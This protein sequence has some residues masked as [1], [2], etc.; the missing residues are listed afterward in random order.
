MGKTERNNIEMY[1]EWYLNELKDAGYIHRYT[2]EAE[3]FEL[4]PQYK[5][6]RNKRHK[7]KEPTVEE[8]NLLQKLVYTYDYRIYWENKSMYLFFQE[9]DFS[10]RTKLQLQKYNHTL[11]WAQYDAESKMWVSDVDVKPVPNAARF[12]KGLNSYITFPILQKALL[13]LYGRY[14]NK[15][16][17]IPSRSS[18]NTLALFP[19]SFTPIRY[20]HTDKATMARKIHFR[21]ITMATYIDERTSYIKQMD[22]IV[23][24]ITDNKVK[25][26][27]IFNGK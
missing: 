18:G 14:V 5:A 20:L 2:R 17:P 12:S 1:F 6:Y 21:T 22:L 26:I 4:F 10:D 24:K 13:W 3:T 23:K 11:F 8:F 9:S 7:T 27:D 25:Q 16:V 19:N 15:V